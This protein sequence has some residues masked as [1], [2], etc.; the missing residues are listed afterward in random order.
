MDTLRILYS[1]LGYF[2]FPVQESTHK[3]GSLKQPA[4][5]VKNEVQI[6]G[7]FVFFAYGV[8]SSSFF[9]TSEISNCNYQPSISE[10]V[11]SGVLL[12]YSGK[13]DSH[14]LYVSVS[15]AAD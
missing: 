15:C 12:S 7:F 4:I 8:A 6:G 13:F 5:P 11:A 1:T 3:F 2:H 10:E 9:L 14:T